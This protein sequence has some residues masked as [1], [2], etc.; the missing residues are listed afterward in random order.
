MVSIKIGAVNCRGLSE[1]VKRRDFFLRCRKKYDISILIDT[2]SK[3][4]KENQWQHEWGYKG[5][6]SYFSSHTGY[7]RGVAILMNSTFNFKVHDIIILF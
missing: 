3:Q 6:F 7:S 5:Y 4:E 1:D 2:H